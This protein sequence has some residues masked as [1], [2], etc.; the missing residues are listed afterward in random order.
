MGDPLGVAVVGL[1]VG[2]AHLWAYQQLPERYRVVAVCD[3]DAGRA[4]RAAARNPGS[5]ASTDLAEVCARD[6]IS[7]V[8]LCTPPGLHLDQIAQVLD[9]GK[10]VVCEKPL[11]GSLAAVDTVARL[12]ADSDRRVMPI[13]Q[14]RW[15]RGLQR[16]KHLVDTG[17]AGPANT[18][19]VEVAWR[20]RADYY[21]VPW[22]GTWAGEL[23]G[24]LTSHAIHAL[25][26]LTYVAGPVASVFAR[27]TTR[28][29]AIETEDC[30]AATFEM[31]DGS[32]AT[33]VATLGSSQEI[34]RHRFNFAHL[35]AESGTSAYESSGEPWTVTPDSVEDEAAIERAMAEFVPGAEGYVGQFE[36]FADALA[37]GGELPVTVSD[38]RAALELL[39]ALYVS[40]RERREV[41]LPIDPDHPAHSGWSPS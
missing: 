5:V 2:K 41:V 20:R 25:D 35:A 14:Y 38:A 28:V 3:L 31:A 9:A 19:S 1:N 10:H 21:A 16:I 23:G 8:N 30:A 32:L 17:V 13:F 26:M 6:D 37:G 22:R 29:N 24:V 34:T 36:R 7:V 4:E 40:S 12:E 15:G 27:T 33:L 18:S 39:T 11:V